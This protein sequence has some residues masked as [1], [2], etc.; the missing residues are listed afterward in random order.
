MQAFT[1]GASLWIGKLII[2][3]VL[4]AIR[5]P[6]AGFAHLWR[7]VALEALIILIGEGLSRSSRLIEVQPPPTNKTALKS[8]RYSLEVNNRL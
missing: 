6:S 3:A 7:L 4:A 1:P 5:N 2:D 8:R